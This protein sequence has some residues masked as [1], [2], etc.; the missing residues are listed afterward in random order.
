MEESIMIQFTNIYFQSLQLPCEEWIAWDGM[1][2]KQELK[3]EDQLEGQKPAQQLIQQITTD[4]TRLVAMKME[5]KLVDSRY[6]LEA[7]LT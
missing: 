1:E 2:K 3:Q 4:W 5:K 6:I 7:K